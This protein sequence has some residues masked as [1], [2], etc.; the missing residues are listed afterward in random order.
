MLNI[1]YRVVLYCVQHMVFVLWKERLLPW[2][3][4]GRAKTSWCSSNLREHK[5]ETSEKV[6]SVCHR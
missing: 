5:L 3:N 4:V 6:A 1:L 2:T